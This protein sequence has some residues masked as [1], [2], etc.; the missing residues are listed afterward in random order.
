MVRLI[1]KDMEKRFMLS[2]CLKSALMSGPLVLVFYVL[3]L[4]WLIMV[5]RYLR[6]KM[7]RHAAGFWIDRMAIFCIGIG[8]IHFMIKCFSVSCQLLE[9]GS[10]DELGLARAIGSCALAGVGISCAGLVMLAV[11]RVVENGSSEKQN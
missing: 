10:I 9:Y 6:G 11:G 1:G 2:T 4:I 8:P 7:D 3:L 5:I